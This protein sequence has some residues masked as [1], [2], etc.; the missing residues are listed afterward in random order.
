MKLT[1]TACDV[2][3]AYELLVGVKTA[4]M[5][6][7]SCGRALVVQVAEASGLIATAVQP[8]I[9]VVPTKNPTVPAGLALPLAE[10]MAM[11]VTDV[12]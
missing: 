6:S 8:V 9:A 4:L 1:T 5:F 11:K 7:L 12:P 2:D 3:D 10:A